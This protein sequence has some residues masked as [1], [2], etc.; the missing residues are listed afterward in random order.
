MFQHYKFYQKS[1]SPARGKYFRKVVQLNESNRKGKLS[2][3]RK[4]A[5]K[6]R[7]KERKKKEKRRKERPMGASRKKITKA[8][9]SVIPQ[10]DSPPHP[11]GLHL[12]RFRLLLPLPPPSRQCS[13]L[14]LRSSRGSSLRFSLFF[15]SLS[16][17]DLIRPSMRS[18]QLDLYRQ[19]APGRPLLPFGGSGFTIRSSTRLSALANQAPCSVSQNASYASE[20]P[21]ANSLSSLMQIQQIR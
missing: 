11:N 5:Q 1:A 6:K 12:V 16:L 9:Q 21:S 2:R 14:R 17:S 10:G 19:A 7:D 15:M 20:N 18:F 13:A 4:N 3:W 8:S